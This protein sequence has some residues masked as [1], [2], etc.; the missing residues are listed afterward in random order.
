VSRMTVKAVPT[1]AGNPAASGS[2]ASDLLRAIAKDGHNASHSD[3]KN[4]NHWSLLFDSTCSIVS[5]V[6]VEMLVS[7]G[8]IVN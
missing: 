7:S 5:F 6:T 4:H 1:L 8:V 2:L 3:L